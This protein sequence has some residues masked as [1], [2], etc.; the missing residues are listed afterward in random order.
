[1]LVRY[2]HVVEGGCGGASS[3]SGPLAALAHVGVACRSSAIC[4]RCSGGE[5]RWC[6]AA[7][8]HLRR[9]NATPLSPAQHSRALWPPESSIK[10]RPPP[11]RLMAPPILRVVRGM[12]ASPAVQVVHGKAYRKAMSQLS[13]GSLAEEA[14]CVEPMAKW[15]HCPGFQFLVSSMHHVAVFLPACMPLL[16]DAT[17]PS[18]H[19]CPDTLCRSRLRIRAVSEWRPSSPT[20]SWPS[21]PCGFPSSPRGAPSRAHAEN[22]RVAPERP[23]PNAP[24]RGMDAAGTRLRR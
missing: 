17:P 7:G 3:T 14:A 1:M 10:L 2:G 15:R 12:R 5:I 6:T 19:G 18:V 21:S 22:V 4:G 13:G 23:R 9:R 24:G 11:P 20:S 16:S 8:V